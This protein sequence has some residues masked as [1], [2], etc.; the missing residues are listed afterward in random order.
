MSLVNGDNIISGF[1]PNAI[2]QGIVITLVLSL[3]FSI[4]A[5]LIYHFSSLTEFALPWFAVGVLAVSSFIG[6]AGAG[7]NAGT[8]G[9]YHGAIVGLAFFLI[10]C[11]VGSLILTSLAATGIVYKFIV[12]TTSGA[13]GGMVGV[14]MS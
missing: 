11:L 7:R 6:S 1:K 12:T 3:V 10:V 14:G 5:G 13:L 4:A 2:I 9:I 8:M